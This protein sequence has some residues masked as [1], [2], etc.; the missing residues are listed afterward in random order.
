MYSQPYLSLTVVDTAQVAPSDGKRG[1][2]LYGL[3]VARLVRKGREEGGEGGRGRE[4]EDKRMSVCV[5]V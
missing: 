4:R 2:S 1:M 5:C 3:H